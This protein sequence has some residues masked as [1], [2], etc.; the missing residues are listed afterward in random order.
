MQHIVLVVFVFVVVVFY[1]V[2]VTGS[3]GSGARSR[4]ELNGEG[5]LLSRT[6]Q[7]VTVLERRTAS[8]DEQQKAAAGQV[9]VR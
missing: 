5:N 9:V 4:R 3:R 8:G 1:L 6:F 7:Q 2:C